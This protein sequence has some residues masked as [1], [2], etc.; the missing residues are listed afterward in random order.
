LASTV[1]THCKNI[2]QKLGVG[3]RR[4]AVASAIELG[5]LDGDRE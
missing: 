5:I 4:Q 2:Y 3:N 1:N